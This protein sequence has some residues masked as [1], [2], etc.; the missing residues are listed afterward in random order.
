M[1][2]CDG[3]DQRLKHFMHVHQK[4]FHA[5]GQYFFIPKTIVCWVLNGK[6]GVSGHNSA[7]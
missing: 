1:F 3:N 4:N 2:L 5:C 6:N 7:L